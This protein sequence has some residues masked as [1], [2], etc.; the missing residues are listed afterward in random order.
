MVFPTRGLQVGVRTHFVQ[1]EPQ[2]LQCLIKISAICVVEDV[3]KY[4]DILTLEFSTILER[5]SILLECESVILRRPLVLHNL[6]MTSFFLR[7][8]FGTQTNLVLLIF[9]FKL[10]IFEM[11]SV[12]QRCNMDCSFLFLCSQNNLLLFA[13]VICQAGNFSSFSHFL[14]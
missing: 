8:P 5:L 2:D 3:S 13:L 7:S 14:G 11:T 12:H 10:C 4:P 9:W 1:G 6:A